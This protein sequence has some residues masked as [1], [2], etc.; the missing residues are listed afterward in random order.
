MHL[1]GCRSGWGTRRVG[2]RYIGG[3]EGAARVGVRGG[4]AFGV[5]AEAVANLCLRTATVA[6]LVRC[7]PL[8]WAYPI[9][10]VVGCN[11][12]TL[13]LV[14]SVSL[15]S[16]SWSLP[17]GFTS[18]GDAG[19][20]GQSAVFWNAHTT[21]TFRCW[22][23]QSATPCTHT[24]RLAGRYLVCAP[25]LIPSLERHHSIDERLGITLALQTL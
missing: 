16:H 12:T 18:D 7:S 10:V 9:L 21:T 1:G 6:A 2:L 17:L 4:L 19:V 8:G 24:Q 25:L 11:V 23:S 20:N 13:L 15:V 3:R 5:S 14:T 22:V